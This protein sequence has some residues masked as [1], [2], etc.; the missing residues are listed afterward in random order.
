MSTKLNVATMKDMEE[1]A[2]TY[3]KY[4]DIDYSVAK[5]TNKIEVCV[6]TRRQA[7]HVKEFICKRLDDKRIK[8]DNKT[9]FEI[10]H[11]EDGWYYLNITNA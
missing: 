4:H 11:D 2:H 7:R 10:D 3:C 1:L 5:G 9:M 8:P 6:E